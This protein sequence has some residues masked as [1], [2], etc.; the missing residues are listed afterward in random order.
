MTDEDKKEPTWSEIEAERWVEQ[1]ELAH[2]DIAVRVDT[3]DIQRMNIRRS[4]RTN[5]LHL[6]LKA[7]KNKPNNLSLEEWADYFVNYIEKED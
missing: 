1:Q 7:Q 6:A 3:N 4:I 2:R 5:A